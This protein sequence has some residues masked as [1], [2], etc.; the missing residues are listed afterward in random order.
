MYRYLIVLAVISILMSCSKKKK[1]VSV[2]PDG[3]YKEVY[4]MIDDSIMEGSYMKYYPDGTVADSCNYVNNKLDGTRKIYTKEGKLEIEESYVNGDFSG[5]YKTFYT[6]GQVKKIQHYVDNK[7]QGEVQEFYEDGLLKA[8][9]AFV[10]NLENGSFQEFHTN[11][12]LHWE[13]FY[14]GG[15]FEQDT[16]KEFDTEGNIIR[17]LYCENGICQTVWTPETGYVDPQK[18]FKDQ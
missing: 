10:D 4:H 13:G 12:K 6:S 15:D 7:I 11:G 18:I 5:P 16:L 8:K 1:V 17:K 2:H 14:Q 9:V 3:Y